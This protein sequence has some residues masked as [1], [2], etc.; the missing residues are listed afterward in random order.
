MN[1]IPFLV[2]QTLFIAVLLGNI[3]I[4]WLVAEYGEI[5][6]MGLWEFNVRGYE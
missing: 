6:L 4:A 1:Y 3:I 2:M 5:S